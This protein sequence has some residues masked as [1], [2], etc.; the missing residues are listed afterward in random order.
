MRLPI[1]MILLFLTNLNC[2][3]DEFNV[4][5][6][7]E[8][9]ET[10]LYTSFVKVLRVRETPELKSK[11]IGILNYGEYAEFAGE[12]SNN[13][14]IVDF[15]GENISEKWI[16]IKLKNG[17]YGWAWGGFIVPLK[18]YIDKLYGIEMMIP[19]TENMA[20]WFSRIDFPD[21]EYPSLRKTIAYDFMSIKNITFGINGGED[22]NFD[23]K[24]AEFKK[25]TTRK[26]FLFTP[27]TIRNDLFDNLQSSHED[28]MLS[29]IVTLLPKNIQERI[30]NNSIET[31]DEIFLN[32]INTNIIK[33]RQFY[34]PDVFTESILEKYNIDSTMKMFLNKYNTFSDLQIQEANRKILNALFP[35]VLPLESETEFSF[36]TNPYDI[37][38]IASNFSEYFIDYWFDFSDINMNL[39]SKISFEEKTIIEKLLK[40]S[41]KEYYLIKNDPS[42]IN[43]IKISRDAK[44][45][46]IDKIEEKI[47]AN[48][49]Y[50][51]NQRDISLMNRW[52]GGSTFNEALKK[53][54]SKD[55]DA[56]YFSY[57]I[58]L[59]DQK[60]IWSIFK[61]YNYNPK[62]CYGT[63]GWRNYKENAYYFASKI[64]NAEGSYLALKWVA[65]TE[66]MINSIK[67]L[68]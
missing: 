13:E 51:L 18:K 44:D 1:I 60:K 8:L 42:T 7:V 27:G 16:K 43:F 15:N 4:P 56:Y 62:N 50:V 57:N 30:V 64:R 37:D 20:I 39:L 14:T 52:W 19:N 49:E 61:K 28:T 12:I 26:T 59:E 6:G 3:S 10:N 34:N 53:L 68:F 36:Y 48:N 47:N 54:R 55:I 9:T 66:I 11:V 5:K 67:H 45:R 41:A 22:F 2:F 32:A 35:D 31:D 25:N 29:Y 40:F 17:Q 58:S 24:Y 46:Y 23:I 65:C 38:A 33:N 21:K 63:H